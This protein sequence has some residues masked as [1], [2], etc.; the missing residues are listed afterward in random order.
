MYKLGDIES[1]TRQQL[2]IKAVNY[3]GLGLSNDENIGKRVRYKN[4]ACEIE[5]RL[6]QSHWL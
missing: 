6:P 3:C 1:E 5:R 2:G 4:P